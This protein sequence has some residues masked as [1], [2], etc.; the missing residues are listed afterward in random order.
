[1]HKCFCLHVTVYILPVPAIRDCWEILNFIISI[2]YNFMKSFPRYS[3]ILCG[4]FNRFDIADVSLNCKLVNLCSASQLMGMPPPLRWNPNIE[5]PLITTVAVLPLCQ[6]PA[7][8][9]HSRRRI[10]HVPL[11][12]HA[13]NKKSSVM[14]IQH[15]TRFVGPQHLFL[16]VYWSV[17]VLETPEYLFFFCGLGQL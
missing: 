10:G 8:T 5:V 9:S 17:G 12:R 11:A 4:D 1:M 14:E 2:I 13:R 16:E 6:I 15:E 7:H 3:V